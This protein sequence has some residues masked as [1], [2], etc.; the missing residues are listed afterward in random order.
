MA[1]DVHSLVRFSISEIHRFA[2]GHPNERFYAFAIDA[3]LL[4]VNSEEAFART[5]QQYQN[6]WDRKARP[7]EAWSELSPHDISDADYLLETHV[8]YSGLDKSDKTACL[9]VINQD[10]ARFRRGGNPYRELENIAS[11]RNNTGD[12]AYHGFAHMDGAVGFDDEAYSLHYDLSDE[13]QSVSAYAKA[14]DEI[15]ARLIAA[16]A[17]DPLRRTPD[18]YATRVEHTY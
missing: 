6:D 3:N 12:W 13:E 1:F 18:F 2:V 4:C 10:R 9:A 11:L 5:L 8:E 15:V 17:F 16:G 7:F 14:M